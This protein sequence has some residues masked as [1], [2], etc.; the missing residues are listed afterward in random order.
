MMS[1]K[2][3]INISFAKRTFLFIGLISIIIIG[4]KP[5]SK[6]KANPS[7]PPM[8]SESEPVFQQHGELSFISVENDT[9][10]IID[11]ELA[12]T[13]AKREKGLMHRKAM[14][15]N[16]GMLFIFDNEERQS[17]WMKNTHIALDLIFVNAEKEIVHIATNNA[18]YSLKQINSYEYAMYVVEVNA[19]FCLKYKINTGDKISF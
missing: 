5:S 14:N 3:F 13:P 4:C 9:M 7:I 16:N 18:P 12:D 8:F 15:E 11:I 17:F 1:K 10:A 19:D 6:P 2:S